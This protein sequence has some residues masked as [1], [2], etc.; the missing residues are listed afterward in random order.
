MIRNHSENTF[1]QAISIYSNSLRT[2]KVLVSELFLLG[3]SSQMALEE[4]AI[5]EKK[6]DEFMTSPPLTKTPSEK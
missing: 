6:G 4:R 3:K 2:L 5:E 1:P